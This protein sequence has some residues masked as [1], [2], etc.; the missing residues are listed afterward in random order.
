MSQHEIEDIYELSPLQ[1]GMLFHTLYAPLSRV[2][3]EQESFPL[4]G[5]VDVPNLI[6]AWQAVVARHSA[7]RASFHWEG[8][9][10]PVQVVHRD[11]QLPIDRQDW[12]TIPAL[13]QQQRL[14]AYL[15]AIRDQG[16]DLSKAPLIRIAMVQL[17]EDAV[18]FVLS[19]HHI[20]LDGWSSRVLTRE[21]WALYEA[22]C[23]G[24]ELRLPPVRPYSDF[25]AWLQRQDPSRAEFFWRRVLKS[26][27]APTKF[28]IDRAA[29]EQPEAGS[30]HGERNVLL[31]ERASS[32]LQQW[33]RE[34]RLT[35]NTL[36]QGAWAIILSRYSR[37]ADIVFGT[38]VSGRPATLAGVES[39]VGLFINTLPLRTQ[40]PP[41]AHLIP[42]L[43]ELQSRQL[44][45]RDYEYSELVHVQRWSDVP[46]GTPLF[47][48]IVIFENYPL[49][50]PIAA[51][52]DPSENTFRCFEKSNYPLNLMVVPGSRID[53]RILYD[54]QRF[55]SA[56]IEG[57]LRHLR[58]VLEGM[59]AHPGLRLG[60][61]P[62]LTAAEHR[63]LVLEW[64]AT[65]AA[66]PAEAG[67]AELFEAQAART[68]ASAAFICEDDCITYAE[69]NSRSNRLARH[70]QTLG[71]GPEVLV[72]ICIDRSIDFV[73]ALLAIF[74]AGGA[75]LPLDPRY[76]KDRLAF[77]VDDAGVGV[78]I[79][80]EHAAPELA[81]EGRK[82]F[83]LDADREV[84]DGYA[85]TAL[86]SGFSP[87]Q[88]AYVI[89]TSGSTGEPKGV[90]VEHGQ[91]LNR[92]HWMWHE[93]PF[94]PAEVACQKTAAGFVDSLWEFF[95]ALLQGIP[96]VIIR[97][98][99]LRDAGRLVSELGRRRVTR[100]WM[101]PSLLRALLNLYGDLQDRLPGLRFWVTSGEALTPALYRQ[102]R[103][104]MPNA[105]LYN[106]YGTSEVWDATWFD[107]TRD[108]LAGPAAP[109]GRP[110]WNVQ[111]YIL[112]ERMQ[113]P[114]IGVGGEL[115]VGGV[116]LAR[117]YLNRPELTAAKFIPNPFSQQPAARLYKTGDLARYLPDGNIEFLGR[118]DQQ[119]KI[120]GFRVEPG[121]IEAV[122]SQHPLVREAVVVARRDDR[123][124]MPLAAYVLA[125]PGREPAPNELR[126]FLAE[127]LPDYMVPSAFVVLDHWP[128]TASGKLDRAGLP[129]PG[130]DRT[131]LDKSF[132]APRTA[133]E[134]VLTQMYADVLGVERVG[135]RDDF[136]SDLGGHSLLATQL[137]SRV[138]DVF[139]IDLPLRAAFDRPTVMELAEQI[140]ADPS[141]RSRAERTAALLLT[142]AECSDDDAEVKLMQKHTPDSATSGVAHDERHP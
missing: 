28:G 75:Y 104:Q 94:S 24:R 138:R 79:T 55:D 31:S 58:T 116:G 37:E 136:F 68:P 102:F 134:R 3:V 103:T 59:P 121:E 108:A 123:G 67:I 117:G 25:I 36:V 48:S 14:N 124:G 87:Q 100:L 8:L 113:P 51:D 33:A 63:R 65:A 16:F 39:M 78:L 41:D 15:G 135:I 111:A 40:V 29:A 77:M 90:A 56:A 22:Y 17:A 9:E 132:L 71:V 64:N 69:L 93:Y 81:A 129:E 130:Q 89:Y 32:A 38:V 85:D 86:G 47:E 35:L 80:Q 96:T 127:R 52:D 61:L 76:P 131:E 27:G 97:D 141:R 92:L 133:V 95:G 2:F 21:V 140:L 42:W 82:L 98:E 44:E 84:L 23:A 43:K 72:G 109:I 105:V 6:R 12:R 107:P 73:V 137:V 50:D 101:V 106:L 10:K 53:L 126:G 49:S 114:P 99:V 18:Q 4:L 139:Q 1:R 26:F 11:V 62:L 122:L 7:L 119:V 110:I 128:L 19:F 83:R 88:L 57:L 45:A 118:M 54:E 66:Y 74:K 5:A 70:L 120:R 112:D 20:L 30:D 13:E 46:S 34:N 125:H 60:D 142:V 115:Y 91:L